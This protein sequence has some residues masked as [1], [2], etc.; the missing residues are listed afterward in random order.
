MSILHKLY[1]AFDENY[2]FRF[3]SVALF[4]YNG[5]QP[6]ILE[7]DRNTF[8]FIFDKAMARLGSML[9]MNQAFDRLCTKIF[10]S[11]AKNTSIF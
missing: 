10:L 3:A 4:N 2:L 11:A 7:Q 9:G 6:R 5:S 1:N 8:L